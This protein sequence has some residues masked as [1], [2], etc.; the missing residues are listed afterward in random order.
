LLAIVMLPETLPAAVGVNCTVN[1]VVEP[2]FTVAG[3]GVPLTV[4][5]EPLAVTPEI[6]TLELPE[7]VSVTFF[8][9]FVPISMLPKLKLMGE[10]DSPGAPPVPLNETD[11]GELE[12]L[13]AIAKVPLAVPV[14]CGAN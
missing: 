10:A 7:F 5:P 13:L 11:I 6:V 2:A 1:V 9:E 8:V 12:A 14:A 4:I 3:N